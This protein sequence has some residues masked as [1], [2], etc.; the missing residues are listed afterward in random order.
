MYKVPYFGTSLALAKKIEETKEEGTVI[1][2]LENE[3]EG[4]TGENWISKQKE[5]P[6]A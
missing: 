3:L 5:T 1:L 2:H 4:F 6:L